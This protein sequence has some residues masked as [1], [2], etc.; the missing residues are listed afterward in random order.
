MVVTRG[1]KAM[2]L[3]YGAYVALTGLFV[4]LSLQVDLAKNHRVFFVLIDSIL[5]AYV[6]LW[7]QWF[8]NKLIEWTNRLASLESR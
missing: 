2:A 8:R 3:F 1:P 7:N 4:S 6:C 5:V